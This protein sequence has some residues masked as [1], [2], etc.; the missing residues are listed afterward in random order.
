MNASWNFGALLSALELHP[1]AVKNLPLGELKLDSRE[2]EQGDIFVALSGHHNDGRDYIAKALE[3]G[4]G[5]CLSEKLTA[6][7]SQALEEYR[8]A[9]IEIENLRE[10]I[11]FLSADFYGRP[12]DSLRTVGVTGTNGK[13]SSCYCITQLGDLLG[14]KSAFV[15]TIGSGFLSNLH[16]SALT[17][18]DPI[19]LQSRLKDFVD[20][21]S[22]FCAMEVSSHA[23]MQHR[24]DGVG[25]HTAVFT[26]L[27][28]DHLDY[29]GS[30]EAYYQAKK[31]LFFLPSVKHVVINVDDA[32]GMR[33]YRELKQE[34]SATL[35]T[36]SLSSQSFECIAD[37]SK[38]LALLNKESLKSHGQT[39]RLRLGGDDYLTSTQLAGEFNISNLL[40]SA[41]ALHTFGR[42][43]F[44]QILA[45]CEE[46][47]APPGRL[48]CFV[49]PTGTKA[50]VDY[51]HT[52]D[53][54]EKA[55]L[56]LRENAAGRIGVVFGCGG[57]RDAAKRPL[58]AK[59]AEQFSDY[60]VI[61]NDNPRGE[62]SQGIID[63][64]LTGFTS[65]EKVTSF[66]DREQAIR[67]AVA[68]AKPED[69][70]LVA[71]KG[72]EDYQLI[73]ERRLAYSDRRLLERIIMEA[74]NE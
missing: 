26:N 11:S 15:G 40:V 34:I 16:A 50:F 45:Q 35:W 5:L 20:E 33:L 42:Y 64:I 4:A 25:I 41:L 37:C 24:V 19:K 17:T 3:Q 74:A 8:H 52:P 9:I 23:L 65:L 38:H 27:S 53:A 66:A 14:A 10:K 67:H 73:G 70:I 60:S 71:G 29:H 47:K 58:M 31:R 59:V 28:H 1:E 12:G 55:L 13:T 49:M 39:L 56:A 2:L 68:W 51:A 22:E 43:D 54:L 21:G 48:E 62:S 72:H 57:D 18:P 69:V 32:F 46:V 63:N 7:Q 6:E 44:G 61:T 36:V 30:I